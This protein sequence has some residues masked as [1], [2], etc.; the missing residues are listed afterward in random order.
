MKNIVLTG[1]MGSGK[2]TVAK[3]LKKFFPN[4]ELI[5]TD[6]LI[7][8]IE[9]ISINEIF[10]QKGEAYFRTLEKKVI[11]DTLKGEGKIISLGGGSLNNNFDFPLAKKNSIIFYLKADVDILFERIKNNSDR[12]LLKCENPKQKLA[13]LLNLRE[14]NYKKADYTID[15]NEISPYLAAHKIK[16][17]YDDITGN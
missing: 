4:F 6:E 3:E 16:E 14:E 10:S 13:D 7:T 11:D 12:P 1:L 9:G 17:I 2:T 15:V 8:K 5:E